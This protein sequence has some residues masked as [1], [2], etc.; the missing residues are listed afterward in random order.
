M[1]LL[2]TRLVVFCC[3]LIRPMWGSV[4]PVNTKH[5]YNICT[6]LDQRRRR[7]ADVVQMLYKCF[8]FA[9]KL[10]IVC[11]YEAWYLDTVYFLL[12]VL[13]KHETWT[14]WPHYFCKVYRYACNHS[15]SLMNI[16]SSHF[17]I[18]QIFYIY[19]VCY[20]DYDIFIAQI[21]YWT[22]VDLMLGQR[23]RRHTNIKSTM[24][25]VLAG[26]ICMQPITATTVLHLVFFPYH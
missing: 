14:W 6:T 1:Y 12:H 13:E 3:G 15:K 4:N 26:Y 17:C 2:R 8:V 24:G 5:L 20:P 23:Q 11:S 7:W 25:P 21:G 18:N 19:Y 10:A 22:T 9:G 16:S